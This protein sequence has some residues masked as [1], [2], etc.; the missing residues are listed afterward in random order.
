MDSPLWAAGARVSDSR[1][2]NTL[3]V[4]TLV[5]DRVRRLG[6]E[7]LWVSLGQGLAACGAVVGVRWLTH[8]LPPDIYGELALGITA[9]TL[10]QQLAFGPL[11]A[12]LLRFFAPAREA[13]EA[14]ALL[15]ALGTINLQISVLI[16]TLAL[17][18]TAGLWL[19][20][21]ARWIGLLLAAFLFSLLAGYGVVLDST[22][23]AAR[24]R[25]VVAFHDGCSQ[26]LRFLAALGLVWWWGVSSRVAMLGFALGAG[27]V[28]ASQFWFF[29]RKVMEPINT[30]EAP[31]PEAAS[32]WARQA[33]LYAWPFAL[34]G[35]FYWAQT[36][37]DRWALQSFAST[38]AVG[39]YAVLYQLGYAPVN[40][41]SGLLV[42]LISPVLFSRAG[43]GHDVARLNSSRRL[44]DRLL[45]ATM[46]FAAALFLT[47]YLLHAQIFSVLVAPQYR[48][49]SPLLPWMVLSG[50]LFAAGQV[51]A[52]AL[53]S[54][55]ATQHLLIPKIV[56][57]LLG[58][59]LNIGGAY[60]L[61]VRGVV[62]AGLTFAVV[63]FLWVLILSRQ[64][65]P[66]FPGAV[67]NKP[68]AG[69]SK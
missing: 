12:S 64:S 6:S 5:S 31:M 59:V 37:S 65:P 27:V 32:R 39:F 57:A 7:F 38:N 69:D 18:C 67:A 56:T 22:Q 2:Q 21:Q 26:W 50:G 68:E 42:Q 51:A 44:N 13:K 16:A 63:Y 10:V 45:L 4:G 36:A 55:T 48:V 34:W 40:M 33:R 61:G 60:W 46:G 35:I 29:Q 47:T 53:L 15:R 58:I 20:G 23:N 17:L 3:S 28:L 25:V 1:T 30:E 66:A 62:Y 49:V 43:S 19:S 54:G 24:Q 14:S 11:A 41:L 9:A 52:L 8:V